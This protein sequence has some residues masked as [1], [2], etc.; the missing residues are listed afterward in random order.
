MT[1]KNL[2]LELVRVQT[3]KHYQAVADLTNTL[4]DNH[5]YSAEQG[6]HESAN[7]KPPASFLYQLA[8]LNAQPVA[9]FECSE[10]E[11]KNFWLEIV[12]HPDFQR[13]GIGSMLMLEAY[14]HVQKF[15]GIQLE[16]QIRDDWAAHHAFYA[17][18]GFYGSTAWVKWW[19]Q[20][21]N[22]RRSSNVEVKSLAELEQPLSN[23]MLLEL[24]NELRFAVIQ[25]E[26]SKPYTLEMLQHDVYGAHWFQPEN[27]WVALDQQDL[28][29]A[30]WMAGY[31]NDPTLFVQFIG[32]RTSHRY[33]GIGS[34]FTQ[35]MVKA[36][37]DG[38]YE[39]VE[40]HTNPE[41][42]QTNLFLEHRGFERRPGY[43]LVKK[44]LG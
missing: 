25:T 2:Q 3:K 44:S 14:K 37:R 21:E 5:V 33:Q 36:C 8:Y 35:R 28:V 26:P 27:F 43:L 22:F 16:A 32:I 23:K 39:G 24:I 17:K 19:L 30:C 9:F 11:N 6:L 42:T 31:K 15:Q 38:K 29:G 1:V 7:T 34:G 10:T 12:V 41:E 20:P 40:A 4:Y 18:H 13:Q